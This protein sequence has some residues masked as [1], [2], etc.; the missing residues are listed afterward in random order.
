MGI[1]STKIHY[2]D[3]RTAQQEV[4]DQGWD[5]TMKLEPPETANKKINKAIQEISAKK[6]EAAVAKDFGLV[7]ILGCAPVRRPGISL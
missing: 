5:L 2:W 7:R 1:W 4:F 3:V 6:R